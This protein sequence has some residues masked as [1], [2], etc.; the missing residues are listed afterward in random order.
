MHGSA[1]P[2]MCAHCLSHMGVLLFLLLQT[3][4]RV[5]IYSQLIQRGKSAFPAAAWGPRGGS[6]SF[7]LTPQ[8]R[9]V[10][11]PWLCEVGKGILQGHLCAASVMFTAWPHP[12]RDNASGFSAA[13]TALREQPPPALLNPQHFLSGQPALKHL[14]HLLRPAALILSLVP[15]PFWHCRFL[16]NLEA[17][18]LSLEPMA[19]LS[20]APSLLSQPLPSL[21]GI[22]VWAQILLD[23]PSSIC[24]GFRTQTENRYSDM[25]PYQSPET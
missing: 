17:P 3:L 22:R 15:V 20:A 9:C 14:V 12:T 7:R 19:A 25:Y 1:V 2:A 21:P 16:F 4:K 10:M 18:V 11:Q 23:G 13:C 6:Q 8:G 24:T 5:G